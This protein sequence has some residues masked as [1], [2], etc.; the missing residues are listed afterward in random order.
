MLI[1]CP[2][3]TETGKKHGVF[4]GQCINWSLLCDYNEAM[5]MSAVDVED[6]YSC[7]S[8]NFFIKK[9]DVHQIA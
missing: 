2:I 9:S 6:N 7:E 4:V 8:V 3:N 5:E 1:Q